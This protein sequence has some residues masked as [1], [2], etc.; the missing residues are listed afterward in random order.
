MK[1]RSQTMICALLVPL[2]CRKHNERVSSYSVPSSLDVACAQTDAGPAAG[3]HWAAGMKP[4]RERRRECEVLGN[5]GACQEPVRLKFH[6]ALARLTARAKRGW[7]N[8]EKRRQKQTA[9][10]ASVSPTEA[11]TM[12]EHVV[13]SDTGN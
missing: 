7:T 4:G 10:R 6:A 8:G 9:R 5:I 13:S 3:A 2:Q 11:T 12:N 1:Q